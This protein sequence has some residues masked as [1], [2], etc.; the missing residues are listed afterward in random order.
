MPEL[1]ESVSP[2][3]PVDVASSAKPSRAVGITALIIALTAV[4]LNVVV[5]SYSFGEPAW[6]MGLLLVLFFYVLPF[7]T[8]VCGILA[9]ILGIVAV[10][11]NRGRVAGGMAVILGIVLLLY[12]VYLFLAMQT[13]IFVSTP[14]GM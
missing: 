10:R 12:T 11:R 3:A 13:T 2:S 14:V 4:I 1:I 6:I 7:A 9:L 5:V 8:P